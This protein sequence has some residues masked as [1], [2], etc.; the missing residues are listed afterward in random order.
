MP[1]V[2]KDEAV[3]TTTSVKQS[4]V[5]AYATLRRNWAD[6]RYKG[7]REKIAKQKAEEKENKK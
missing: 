5:T 7:I 2:N 3:T 1:I 6:K 4:K